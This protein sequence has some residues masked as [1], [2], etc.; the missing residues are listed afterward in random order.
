[1]NLKKTN[2][3]LRGD[4]FN[5][6]IFLLPS[7]N[8]SNELVNDIN[9]LIKNTFKIPHGTVAKQP[10]FSGISEIQLKLVKFDPKQAHFHRF[11]WEVGLNCDF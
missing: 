1:M 6:E 8:S 4:L 9:S 5:G 3:L 11:L 10:K 2:R 7:T